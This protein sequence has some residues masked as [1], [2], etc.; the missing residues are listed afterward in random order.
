[1]KTILPNGIPLSQS[2]PKTI[3]DFSHDQPLAVPYL[4][5]PPEV[6][7]VSRGR[8]L[9]VDDFL[10]DPF[11]TQMHREYHRPVKYPGNPVFFPESPEETCPDFP[12]C[13]IAKSG[14]VWFDDRDRLF[15][16]WYMTGYLGYAALATSHDGVHWERPALDVV[17]GTNLILPKDI[18]PD[19]GSVLIDHAAEDPEER[20]KMLLR[21]PNGVTPPAY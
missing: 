12:P 20:Y 6:I 7:D 15:K 13:A 14:G 8:Q 16:M 21:E 17:P 11:R 19:S 18:H 1:M 5:S 3:S 9:F 2:E 4:E 10:V